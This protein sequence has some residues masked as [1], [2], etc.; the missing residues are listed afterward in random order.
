MHTSQLFKMREG[1]V[2]VLGTR[3]TEF[4]GNGSGVPSPTRC[5][6]SRVWGRAHFGAFWAW[7]IP[8]SD[9][10]VPFLMILSTLGRFDAFQTVITVVMSHPNWLI[11]CQCKQLTLPDS[12]SPVWNLIN[13]L[14]LNYDA[15]LAIKVKW[16]LS[17][18]YD[19]QQIIFTA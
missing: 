11:E 8:F 9:K 15:E 10:N 5:S 16:S 12:V 19:N 7:K 13:I 14:L 18:V 6:P 1:S 4:D 2:Q 3:C 17:D